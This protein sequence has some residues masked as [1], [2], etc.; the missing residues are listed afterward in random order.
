MGMLERIKK[1]QFDGFKDFVIN[2][3]TTGFKS[4][5]HILSLAIL[6]DPVF[7]T[8]VMKNIKTFDDFL[9]LPTDEIEKVLESQDQV[10]HIFAKGL[11]GLDD[12][13]IYSFKS[14]MPRFFSRLKDELSYMKDIS[15][16]EKEGAVFHLL[17]I[18]R[19]L[20]S[21]DKIQGFFWHLPPVEVFYPKLFKDGE[22]TIFFE[23]GVIAASGPYLKSQREGTWKHF[24]DTG[25]LFAQGDYINGEKAGVWTYYYLSGAQKS[26]GLFKNDLKNGPWQE[27][28]RSGVET[29]VHYKDGIK[30]DHSSSN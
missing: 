6:E 24:Y 22:V 23:S 3:E 19:N 18:V 16:S 7:M 14:T 11:Y 2:L 20:Q 30:E 4:R 17:K 15:K 5:S 13:L 9:N 28:D 10:P 26:Q 12:H 25:K 1:R 8:Y 29:L 27:W 21:D